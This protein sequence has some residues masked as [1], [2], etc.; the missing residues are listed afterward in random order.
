MEH[1]VSC[2]CKISTLP[3][4]GTAARLRAA[5]PV[6]PVC[7]NHCLSL[8]ITSQA[9]VESPFN[10]GLF[11]SAPDLTGGG[12]VEKLKPPNLKAQQWYRIEENIMYQISYKGN[13]S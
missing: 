1:A 9:H 8:L 4:S 13:Y 11:V 10:P 3:A 7:K 12:P 5:S 2:C 6:S